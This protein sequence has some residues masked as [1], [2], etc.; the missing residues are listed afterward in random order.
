MKLNKL[1]GDCFWKRIIISFIISISLFLFPMY[2]LSEYLVIESLMLKGILFSLVFVLV[3]ISHFYYFRKNKK[4]ANM[5]L[6]IIFLVMLV[7][8]LRYVVVAL[9]GMLFQTWEWNWG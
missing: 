1:L 4:M 2:F 7:D 8:L 5:I 3:S 9:L 6:I